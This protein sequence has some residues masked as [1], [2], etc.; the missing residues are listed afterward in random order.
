[1]VLG[2]GEAH[3]VFLLVAILVGEDNHE[4]LAGVLF[5]KFIGQPL[6]GILI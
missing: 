4:I 2:L 1:M 3:A 6:D 5:L